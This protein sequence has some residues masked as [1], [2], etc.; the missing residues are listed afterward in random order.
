MLLDAL[1]ATRSSSPRHRHSNRP[2]AKRASACSRM[3]AGMSSPAYGSSPPWSK[4][5]R[6]PFRSMETKVA[7]GAAL[8]VAKLHKLHDRVVRGRE[9]R[10]HDKDAADVFRYVGARAVTSPSPFACSALAHKCPQPARQSGA[11]PGPSHAP[12]PSQTWMHRAGA[13]VEQANGSTQRITIGYHP[14]AD[15]PSVTI[16]PQPEPTP[17]TR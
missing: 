15:A 9:D 17:E 5:D 1:E 3:R 2:W 13:T 11:P 8:L 14:P 10:L 12:S 7:G 4:A 6:S 16:D